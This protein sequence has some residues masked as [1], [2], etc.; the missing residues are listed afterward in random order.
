MKVKEFDRKIARADF[1][2]K[3]QD[4]LGGGL[5]RRL[6]EHGDDGLLI[7][8][9][10]TGDDIPDLHALTILAMLHEEGYFKED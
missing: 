2:L 10:A 6:Y 8:V 5:R 9:N 7:S 3:Q 4:D 1:K